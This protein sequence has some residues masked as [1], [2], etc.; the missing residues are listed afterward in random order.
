MFLYLDQS[1][2]WLIN[3]KKFL[4]DVKKNSISYMM[5]I[6]AV[7][8][9]TVFGYL[10]L[11]YM[12]I[13]FQRFNYQEGIFS[14][15]WIGF[16]NFEF[17][18]KSN[19]FVVVTWNTFKLNFMFIIA[20]T[21]FAIIF[22]VIL[23]EVTIKK[24]QKVI[25]PT[26]IMPSFISWIIVSM[27]ITNFLSIDKGV[28]N[29]MLNS[30]GFDS[31][32]WFY[33]PKYWPAILTIVRIWKYS[34]VDIIIYLAVIT[35]IDTSLYEA[36]SIDGASR[37][38]KIAYITVPLLRPVAVVLILLSLGRIFYGEF[39]MIYAIVGDNG[40]LF[41][42]TD[43]IDTFVFR[44]LRRHSNPSAAMAVG[45]FQSIVGFVFVFGCN[46]VAKKIFMDEA[47]F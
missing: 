42:T 27:I 7:I 39:A 9:I 19:H 4:M 25:Q 2:E 26:V 36:A 6:P 33:E 18:F 17:F 16:R 46:W 37:F 41:P 10:T 31:I 44:T 32:R 24:F 22:A 11:P 34:G 5:A 1:E 14:S 45:M 28:I 43:V 40:L 38:Q 21:I 13:A 12:I 15:E 47:L 29:N 8:Y 30:I 35:S 23:N 20:N 3:M